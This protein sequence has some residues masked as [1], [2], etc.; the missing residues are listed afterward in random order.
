L[1]TYT[2]PATPLPL[3]HVA[4]RAWAD[5]VHVTEHLAIY[6]ASLRAFFDAYGSG[7]PPAGSFFVW[8]PVDDGEAFSVAAYEQQAVTVL[9]GAYLS[10]EDAEG[11]NPGQGFIRAALVDGPEKAAELARRLR[12]VKL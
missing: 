8:L 9:P 5:E 2:G 3:Q 1:R 4:A 6:R 12:A 11:V 10:A 7:E